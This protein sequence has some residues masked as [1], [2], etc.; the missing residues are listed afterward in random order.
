MS[1]D[2]C[3]LAFGS[4]VQVIREGYCLSLLCIVRV[5]MKQGLIQPDFASL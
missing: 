2:E 3:I 4:Y 5:A 1:H